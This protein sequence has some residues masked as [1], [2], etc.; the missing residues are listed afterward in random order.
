VGQVDIQSV[1][2][3]NK[4]DNS[5]R[6][7]AD[8]DE[9]EVR[10]EI[11]TESRSTSLARVDEPQMVRPKMDEETLVWSNQVVEPRCQAKP[12]GVPNDRQV[13]HVELRTYGQTQLCIEVSKTLLGKFFIVVFQRLEPQCHQHST[14]D[15]QSLFDNIHVKEMW[16][17]QAMQLLKRFD[18]DV[19]SFTR[20][21]VKFNA[22]FKKVDFG[23]IHKELLKIGDL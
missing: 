21:A 12:F 4:R 15:P 16:Q 14:P 13:L 2:H 5:A 17:M 18:N 9:G 6:I 7:E 23:P 10:L 11:N 19:P 20:E 3:R 22:R 8:E 1:S